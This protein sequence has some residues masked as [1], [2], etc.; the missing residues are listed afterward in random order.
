MD[1]R[2]NE[3][4]RGRNVRANHATTPGIHTK[5]GGFES[6]RDLPRIM[7]GI[8]IHQKP[9]LLSEPL[10]ST[11]EEMQR[12]NTQMSVHWFWYVDLSEC[13][14]KLVLEG[15]IVIVDVCAFQDA[16]TGRRYEYVEY[17]N[18][19]VLGRKQGCRRGTTKV[20]SWWR[21][22]FWHCSYCLCLCDE[23]S[24]NSDRF[25]NLRAARADVG[26]NM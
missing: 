9:R 13:K 20:D 23:Q 2:S 11:A 4:R 5:R 12:E 3:T 15:L 19:R 16:A 1:V 25:F 22:L 18:G 10:L 7:L 8:H 21:W 6:G 26:N 17:E 14:W 24:Y